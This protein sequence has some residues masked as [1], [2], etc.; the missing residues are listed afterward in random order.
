MCIHTRHEVNKWYLWAKKVSRIHYIPPDV[1]I[2]L[3]T[4]RLKVERSSN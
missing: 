4:T 1:R 2:E 3:T